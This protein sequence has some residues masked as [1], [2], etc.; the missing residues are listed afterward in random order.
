MK[1]GLFFGSFNPIH[2]GHLILA[3]T[4]IQATDLD[5]IWFVVSPQNPFKE[6]TSLLHEFDRYELVDIAIKDDERF[7]VTDIEFRMPKPIYTVDT[8]IRLKEQFTSYE[9][10]LL[11]GEDNLASFHKWKNYE[12]LL[13]LTEIC[14]YKRSKSKTVRT[15][16]LNSPKVKEVSAA[17]LEISSTYIR[18]LIKD[19]KSIK[20]LVPEVVEKLINEKGYYL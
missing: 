12:Q 18:T 13:E 14:Y 10:T 19:G 3:Q 5:K 17:Y 4:L 11:M 20:Y 2:A 15:E 9:F 8:V 6:K 7:T 16:I 1:V